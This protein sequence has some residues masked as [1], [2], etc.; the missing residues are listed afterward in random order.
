MAEFRFSLVVKR[1]FL[2]VLLAALA[3]CGGGGGGGDP[4][5]IGGGIDDPGDGT[6]TMFTLE[7]AM[8]D[9]DGNP[10]TTITSSEPATFSVTVLEGRNAVPNEVVTVASELL[11]ITPGSGTALTNADGVAVFELASAGI[12]G[13]GT[14]V[15]SAGDATA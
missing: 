14:L 13:A 8:T 15:V 5:F 6:T 2:S 10:T 4:G 11:S 1:L 7:L 9:A 3:A 12:S